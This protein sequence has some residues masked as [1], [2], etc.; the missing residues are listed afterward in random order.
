MLKSNEFITLKAIQHVEGLNDIGIAIQLSRNSKY[1]F[2][3]EG[4][5]III[6]PRHDTPNE[7]LIRYLWYTD[8][9]STQAI[10][11]LHG[12]TV[13]IS[14]Y[15]YTVVVGDQFEKEVLNIELLSLGGTRINRSY[16][17]TST[18][19]IQAN[20]GNQTR[21]LTM[22]LPIQTIE[23]PEPVINEFLLTPL[24]PEQ[25]SLKW[26]GTNPGNFYQYRLVN[27]WTNEPIFTGVANLYNYVFNIPNIL[28]GQRVSFTLQVVKDNYVFDQLTLSLLFPRVEF[29]VFHRIEEGLRNTK[30]IYSVQEGQLISV[31]RVWNKRGGFWYT[32]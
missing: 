19:I 9:K 14:G 29:N 1:Y 3:R 6:K 20:N 22:E 18:I 26:K 16:K 15:N 31:A 17:S 10:R 28:R 32:D 12:T 7:E 25:I 8:Y 2:N 13:A 4:L 21:I 30:A 27:S 23:L 24:N 5:I 11:D